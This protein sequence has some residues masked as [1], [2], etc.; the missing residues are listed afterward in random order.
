MDLSVEWCGLGSAR[1]GV[2][3]GREYGMTC[4]KP[5]YVINRPC[6]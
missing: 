2:Q 6:S 4:V 5:T 1:I 3:Y